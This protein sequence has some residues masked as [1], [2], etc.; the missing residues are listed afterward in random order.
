MT[1]L[2]TVLLNVTPPEV[3]VSTDELVY[4]AASDFAEAEDNVL[5]E[6]SFHSFHIKSITLAGKVQIS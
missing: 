1:N 5:P 3:G 2:Y 4:V 6:G